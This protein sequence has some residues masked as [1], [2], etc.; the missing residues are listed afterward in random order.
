MSTDGA[1]CRCATR[2]DGIY[3]VLSLFLYLICDVMTW[4]PNKCSNID[5]ADVA[6]LLLRSDSQSLLYEYTISVNLSWLHTQMRRLLCCYPLLCHMPPLFFF[7]SKKRHNAL[8]SYIFITDFNNS[9]WM[10]KKK[11]LKL[12]SSNKEDSFQ[13]PKKEEEKKEA[14]HPLNLSQALYANYRFSEDA[15]NTSPLGPLRISAR[16]KRNSNMFLKA[17]I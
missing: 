6:S 3:Y 11:L 1:S 2:N 8:K 12:K 17:F 9:K 4:T 5:T 14:N 7:F 13:F 16:C 15:K 10:K